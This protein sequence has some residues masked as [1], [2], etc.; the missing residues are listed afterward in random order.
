MEIITPNNA[1][2]VSQVE[3]G[4]FDRL[5]GKKAFIKVN[6]REH[7]GYLTVNWRDKYREVDFKSN[8][9]NLCIYS[10]TY[11]NFTAHAFQG[12]RTII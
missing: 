1:V 10:S 9:G 11:N 2:L 5:D 6:G 3:T 4:V 8:T 12:M 7:E